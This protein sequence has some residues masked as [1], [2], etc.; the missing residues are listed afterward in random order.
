MNSVFKF[1]VDNA[2]KI[3]SINDSLFKKIRIKAFASGENAHTL[4]VKEEVLKRAATTVY[5][6]PILWRYNPYLEDAMGH[7]KD[8]VPCGFV[9]ESN[10]NPIR[11]LNENG[12]IYL[13][14][15]ALIW[16]RYSGKLV[17][18]FIRD[19][20]KKDV[21]IEIHYLQNADN[22]DPKPEIEDFVITG[23][24]ILGEYINP[25]CKGCEAEMLEFSE[26]KEK[27]LKTME[28][29]KT[30]KIKND[31]ESSVDGKWENPRR[32]LFNPIIKSNNMESL[33][34]EAYLVTGELDGSPEITK[35]KY[36]HHVIRDGSLV[37][38][39]GGLQAA[40]QRASQ[41][42]IVSG[43]VKEHL[44]RHYKELGLNSDNFAEFSISKEDFDNYFC[45]NLKYEGVGESNM[46]ED[47]KKENVQKNEEEKREEA[48]ME[49]NA[50]VKEEDKKKDMAQDPEGKE[51]MSVEEMQCK[52]E[53]MAKR[54]QELETDN[55]A[56]MEKINCMSDYE[57]L[58]KFKQDTLDQKA[59]E[60]E[61][62]QM[63]KVMSDIESRGVE[64]GEDE[65]KEIMS[66]VGEFSSVEAWANFAKARVFD[67]VENISGV[68]RIGL[69]FENSD[70]KSGSIWD[71]I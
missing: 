19:D 9:P 67:S 16:T 37:I 30:I 2:E 28:D 18:I 33:L 34:K 64:M 35:F 63:E 56:Y 49:E 40:F 65:K 60:E 58:K 54:I 31:K 52:M 44:M 46:A 8:E 6:K 25:A 55:A 1:S 57:D 5:N 38:H 3:K 4:P 10:D 29:S 20:M 42:G 23:I 69:P 71:E 51:K 70:R 61:M 41:Q 15:D 66:K 36:P 12:R 39:K 22:D 11:F 45:D 68:T 32:K 27:Y 59:K 21:S 7:E 13:V 17:D 43:K 48:K 26:D 50:E 53:E 14:I 47:M 24:T 62:A